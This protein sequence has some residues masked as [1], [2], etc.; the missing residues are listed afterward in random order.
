MT[1]D[2]CLIAVVPFFVP[3]IASPLP[4]YR[5]ALRAAERTVPIAYSK[6][7]RSAAYDTKQSSHLPR[8]DDMTTI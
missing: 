4:A 2:D 5:A 1:R 7:I 8:D 6:V 3:P